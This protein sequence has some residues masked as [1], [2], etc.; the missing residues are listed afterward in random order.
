MGE[1]DLRLLH[2]SY[3]RELVQDLICGF[4]VGSALQYLLVLVMY[5][6]AIF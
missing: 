2:Q 6:Q 5:K 3:S 4:F 1:E